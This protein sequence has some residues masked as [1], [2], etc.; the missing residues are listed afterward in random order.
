MYDYKIIFE[1][2]F[3]SHLYGTTTP[4]SDIDYRGVVV[5]YKGILLSPFKNFEQQEFSNEDRV[6]FSI[7]KFFQLAI[8]CNP[9]I[10]EILFAANATQQATREWFEIYEN[11]YLFLSTRAR[12]TFT[13]YAYAQLKRIKLHR[14]YLLNPPKKEPLRS[15][16]GLKDSPEFGLE[17]VEVLI[18]APIETIKES[19][20]D[21]ALAEKS[22]HDA[23]QS[24]N[25]YKDW[26]KN[27]NE[28]RK[29]IEAKYGYDTKHGMHLYRLLTEGKELLER[30]TITLPRPDAEFLLQIRN[31][32][33]SY[34]QLIEVGENFKKEMEE[35]KTTLPDKPNISILENLYFDVLEISGVLKG[36]LK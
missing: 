16:Y 27:R 2:L 31:G 32:L 30:L 28:K 36:R 24:W 26:E 23:R 11:R 34:E 7:R 10:L 9:N 25:S 8:D 35:T 19:W 17:K 18:H 29:I 15:D 6:Y 1:T 33:Y 22:Y 4:E 13:G 12:Q 21:Y 5:P 20:R 3:G 14:S